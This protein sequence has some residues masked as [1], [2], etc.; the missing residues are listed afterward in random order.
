VTVILQATIS[1]AP[2]VGLSDDLDSC[3]EITSFCDKFLM[4][5]AKPLQLVPMTYDDDDVKKVPVQVGTLVGCLVK[6]SLNSTRDAMKAIDRRQQVCF[7][8]CI[9]FSSIF[10][11][12]TTVSYSS[13]VVS[14]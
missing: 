9:S 6:P 5:G 2:S 10:V 12:F 14:Q 11:G 8:D 4:I 1:S 3:T 7:K 13:F